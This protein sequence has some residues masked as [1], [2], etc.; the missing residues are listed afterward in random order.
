M[1][2]VLSLVRTAVKLVLLSAGWISPRYSSSHPR[3]KTIGLAGDW[4]SDGDRDWLQVPATFAQDSKR[5]NAIDFSGK[6]VDISK[7][8]I[9]FSC[10]C[11]QF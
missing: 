5:M 3:T 11:T 6:C 8:I 1:E 7:E 4:C 9:A 10:L 2:M